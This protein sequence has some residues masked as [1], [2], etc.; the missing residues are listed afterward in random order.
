MLEAS[1]AKKPKEKI[2]KAVTKRDKTFKFF[3]LKLTKTLYLILNNNPKY[4]YKLKT[5]LLKKKQKILS[6][7]EQ[8]ILKSISNC[9][10]EP[11]SQF[12]VPKNTV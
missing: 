10:R 12:R 6:K 3:K 4:K 7:H 5:H 8:Q 9:K 1:H 11:S 2:E